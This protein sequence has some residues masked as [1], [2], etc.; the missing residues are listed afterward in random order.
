[1]MIIW[2]CDTLLPVNSAVIPRPPYLGLFLPA[3]QSKQ[4]FC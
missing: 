3:A 1:M 2:M 4:H